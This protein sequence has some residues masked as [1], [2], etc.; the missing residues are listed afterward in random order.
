M[1]LKAS[2]ETPIFIVGVPRS[3]TTLLR[4]ILT[5]HPDICIP[6]EST[7]FVDLE[8]K[9]GS[10][11]NIYNQIDEFIEE[12]YKNKKFREWNI[13]RLELKK[14]L[15]ENSNLQYHNCI[16][17][18]YQL[19]LNKNNS[20]ASIWGDKN[21]KYVYH[22][23][24]I[25]KYFPHARIIHIVRDVRA[26]Y[27]SLHQIE[28]NK[29]WDIKKSNFTINRVT[30]IWSKALDIANNYKHD[31]RFYLLSYE[32]LVSNPQEQIKNLCN[33]LKIGF[34]ERML[35]FYQKNLDEGL[36]PEHRLQWHQN[37][38]KPVSS[39]QINSW[40]DKLS[41]S[42]IEAIEILNKNRIKQMDYEFLTSFPRY[43]GLIKLLSEY[44]VEKKIFIKTQKWRGEMRKL[45]S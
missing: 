45:K 27:S 28:I 24:L 32:K 18:I 15:E 22:T 34:D 35:L 43:K 17:S 31:K 1:N 9:Y 37:T 26:V 44:I 11:N 10:S 5:S 38:L 30:Q 21:P 7:F 13:N 4:L 41:I 14:K 42:E 16:S 23:D 20:L 3:G 40:Q 6:P 19:Y 8:Q 33:W 39:N 29:L 2:T 12:L 36:V 25:F